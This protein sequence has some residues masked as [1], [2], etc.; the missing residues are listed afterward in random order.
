[1]SL[2]Q[3]KTC[4]GS[5][6]DFLIPSMKYILMR[7]PCKKNYIIKGLELNDQL[8]NIKLF[9]REK[10]KFFIK[11]FTDVCRKRINIAIC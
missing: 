4:E 10:I 2:K 6:G 8:R 3:I 9:E 7:C 1:M 5:F 11:D